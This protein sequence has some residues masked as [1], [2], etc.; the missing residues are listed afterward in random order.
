MLD[1]REV[2]YRF[3]KTAQKNLQ[4]HK[5]LAPIAHFVTPDERESHFVIMRWT[6]PEGKFACYER[7]AK[8]ARD[9]HALAV[10]LVNDVWV[11]NH[12]DLTSYSRALETYQQGDVE[13]DH[14]AECI[15]VTVRSPGADDFM[16]MCRYTRRMSGDIDFDRPEKQEGRMSLLPDW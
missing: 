10:V 9:R 6:T 15:M 5:D 12:G 4:R 13:R 3:M 7:I 11:K 16:L 8:E 1:L 14:S 2:A